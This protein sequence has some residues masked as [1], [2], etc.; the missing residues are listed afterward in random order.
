MRI[1]GVL[2]EKVPSHRELP[3]FN[4]RADDSSAFGNGLRDYEEQRPPLSEILLHGLYWR[5]MQQY[6]SEPS[7]LRLRIV[8]ELLERIGGEAQPCPDLERYAVDSASPTP[9]HDN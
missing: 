6:L 5:T 2:N 4:S 7:H 9:E 1:G 3:M 8:R